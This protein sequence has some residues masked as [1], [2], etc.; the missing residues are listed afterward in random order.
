M[1]QTIHLLST[2]PARF[3]G[4]NGKGEL[5]K[6]YDADFTLVNLWQGQKIEAKTMHSK[7][8]YTPFEGL[9]VKVQIED[10]FLRGNPVIQY[11]RQTVQKP[12]QGQFVKRSS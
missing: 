1:Q 9:E 6:S 12:G 8:K 2:N 7:G 3:F 5:K 4:L 11:S 10:V